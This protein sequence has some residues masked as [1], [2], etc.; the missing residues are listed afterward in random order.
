MS[1]NPPDFLRNESWLFKLLREMER[2]R[3]R[4]VVVKL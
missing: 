2:V 3:E 4:D 1:P